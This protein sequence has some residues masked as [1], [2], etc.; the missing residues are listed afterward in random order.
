[1]WDV[2]G[3]QCEEALFAVCDEWEEGGKVVAD[4]SLGGVWV[5]H[6]ISII[7][8]WACDTARRFGSGEESPLALAT[9]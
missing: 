1:V 8:C 5:K 3:R 4:L 6:M 7:I 9:V 2:C